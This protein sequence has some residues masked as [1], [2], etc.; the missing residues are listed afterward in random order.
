MDGV[1]VLNK[2]LGKTSHDMV[3]FI[4][5]LTGIKKVGH[6]GTLDPYA[7]G[8]L[9]VCIGKAT[10]AADMI[11]ASDKRYRTEIMLGKTTDTQDAHGRVLTQTEV[12]V[13]ESDIKNAVAGFIGEIEQ[14]PPMYSAIK[15]NGQKLYELAR[16]GIE[17]EREARKIVIYS[18][19]ICDISKKSDGV[20]IVADIFCSKGTYIRTLCN[21]IG[22]VL[23]TGAYMNA[24]TRT[25]SGR[26]SIDKSY[27]C[28]ELA[29]MSGNI[30]PLVIRT[31]DLFDYEKI[32]VRDIQ[33]KRLKDGVR[34]SADGINEGRI[35]RVYDS[36]GNFLSLSE[37][38]EGRLVLMKSFW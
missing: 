37:C 29:N 11:T 17:I 8:V 19:D 30:E 23:G 21:D 12:N 35:Y 32:K 31:E 6:T 14:I 9:P 33:A 15:K 22:K 10:K 38:H 26:F 5:K 16:K 4:R 3:Y 24:L 7:D 20:S 36:N 27:T 28:E 1:I 25:A 2:P 13:T 34:I 18:I